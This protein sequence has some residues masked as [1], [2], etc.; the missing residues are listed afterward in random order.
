VGSSQRTPLLVVAVAALAGAFFAGVLTFD[1]VAHLDRQ[2]HAITCSVTPGLSAPDSSGSSGCHAA[3]MSPYSSV[4]RRWTWGGIPISL[5]ALA[6]F[7]FLLFRSLDL[8]LA[9]AAR[10]AQATAF[11]LAATL[12]PLF[13]SIVYFLL[14]VLRLKT[15]CTLC[16]ALYVASIAC[17]AAALVAHRRAAAGG[18]LRPVAW[19]WHIVQ[20]CEGVLFVAIPVLV[21]LLVK[22]AYPE[23]VAHCGGLLHPEDR[24]QVRLPL[25]RQGGGVPTI[26]VLDPLCPA[27]R[28]LSLR[29]GASG[30]AQQLDREVVLFPLDATC[31]WMVSESLHPGSCT[32]SEAILAAGPQAETVLTWALDHQPE[33]RTLGA[34]SEKEL[35]ARIVKE[36]PQLAGALGSP[37]VKS[38]LNRSLRWVVANSLPVLTPQVFVGGRKV[39]DEDTDL[40]LEYVL[41]RLLHERSLAPSGVGGR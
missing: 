23:Q 39:C 17:F 3:L 10:P 41:T 4:A 2:V 14:S 30:L 36:F 37:A 13:A 38:R 20:F 22:P 28:A 12:L 7:A 21:Y 26:E 25:A 19:G 27:C 16:T 33:L 6:V 31:N 35:S 34:R 29:L 1:F 11:L 9:G 8:L 40:G 18:S 5:P 15:L 24:Y 32:V